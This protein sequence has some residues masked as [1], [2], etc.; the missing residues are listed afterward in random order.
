MSNFRLTRF[1]AGNYSYWFRVSGVFD[2]VQYLEVLSLRNNRISFIRPGLFNNMRRLVYLDLTENWISLVRD[3]NFIFN[4]HCL[5]AP[6][7][8]KKSI[9]TSIKQR[10]TIV[11]N[12]WF[13][14]TIAKRQ[15][16]Y[17]PSD[18]ERTS[19][20]SKLLGLCTKTNV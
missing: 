20:R 3:Y 7:K 6:I 17:W 14:C 1:T 18:S 11:I 10:P 8:K 16:V 2:D 15:R 12:L 4:F 13:V 5:F 9:F 19:S